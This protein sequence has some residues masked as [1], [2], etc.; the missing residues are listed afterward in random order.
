MPF[1]GAKLLTII[2]TT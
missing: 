1:R 2:L